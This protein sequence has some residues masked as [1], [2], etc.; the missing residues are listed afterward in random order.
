MNGEFVLFYVFA[1]LESALLFLYL[2]YKQHLR[3]RVTF[4]NGIKNKEQYAHIPVIEE[5]LPATNIRF[6]AYK[7]DAFGTFVKYSI[8][9]ASIGWIVIFGVLIGDYYEIFASWSRKNDRLIFINHSN[10]SKVFIVFWHFTLAWFLTLQTKKSSMKT[11][12]LSPTEVTN[13]EFVLVEKTR[14]TTVQSGDMGRLVEIA[15]K[16]ESWLRNYTKTNISRE[17]KPMRTTRSGRIYVEFE[18]VRYIY[19]EKINS[20]E[21]YKFRVAEN[22]AEL[23]A[24]KKGLSE[25]E[26]LDRM[27]LSGPNQIL[28]EKNTFWEGIKKE[29]SGIFYLYQLM[30]L[31]I[32]Y[33][34]AYYY[35]GLV[36]T[37][38]II[39]SG[40]IKVLVSNAAQ[41]RVLE[42][43]TYR[44]YANVFRNNRWTE[45]PSSHLVVGDIMEI[46]T[47]GH[48]LS[49]DC[50]IISGDVVVD[51]STLTGE[52]LPVSKISVK[53]D[54]QEFSKEKNAKLNCLF[55]GTTVL[56]TQHAKQDEKIVAVVLATGGST[57]KGKLVRD[58]L[59][60]I[61]FVFVFTEHLKIVVPLL[62][63]WGIVL[64]LGSMALNSAN[65]SGSWFYG[66]FGISQ[67][68]SPVLPAVLVIGQSVS[69]ER[70]RAKGIMCVD[71]N[72]IT[73][74]GKV[75][76][77]CF[78]KT[79]T[80]TKEGLE[81]GGVQ[82]IV[83]GN[84]GSRSNQFNSFSYEMKLAM[85]T[86]HSLALAQ[87]QVV[88]NFVDVELFRATGAMIDAQANHIIRPLDGSRQLKILR[89]FEFVHAHA[90]MSSVCQDSKTE[91][92]FLFLKGS[93]EKILGMMRKDSIPSNFIDM[94]KQHALDGYYVI[95]VAMKAVPIELAKDTKASREIYEQDVELLGLIL[96]RNELKTDTKQS[97]THL[98][99]GGVRTV[100]ITGDH[101]NTA[102]F[103]G[104]ECGMLSF[105]EW[106]IH[107]HILMAELED[108]QL[109]WQ[110]VGKKEVVSQELVEQL[111]YRSRQGGTPVELVI[112][113]KAFNYLLEYYWLPQF[114]GECR[115]FARMSPL[116]KAKCVRL[117]MAN[118]ITA[119]CG[120]G[121]NDAGALK[122]SHAGIALSGNGSSV[123]SHFSSSDISINSCVEL[124]REARCSLDVSFASYK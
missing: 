70:L 80:L 118:H 25:N 31:L 106:G 88:G 72:R 84:L 78:D 103:V 16:V 33:F 45:I 10:L 15:Q 122:A 48:P 53:N 59:Y 40:I 65:D 20:F 66:M 8:I 54:N 120:D 81:F 56:E 121:G 14:A 18:C 71:L 64:L 124:L 117:H 63:V 119:M 91:S 115:I 55:A 43:A 37:T 38:I 12:F 2:G 68:L 13:A 94:A 61:P 86:C 107:P 17:I 26:A 62:I 21:P 73:L 109:I 99:Q 77:F 90:Y 47:T 22:N 46:E 49:V 3:Q 93:Y 58:I 85:Q 9:I 1:F 67:V 83:D 75:K 11:L 97:L 32:W 39:G 92:C 111:I 112:V 23:I 104:K 101:A 105:D 27:E 96:F 89:R 76:V 41:Q 57:E 123:V 100:M 4:T 36:L 60:P 52:A 6:K 19:N 28:F 42:M 51:E 69:A 5:G 79:G 114:I 7:R 44:G 102:L 98:R 108:Q 113:G 110:D 50:A 95:A 29:F 34:Y 35:M 30:M 24:M 82:E 116:D 87:N 74:A